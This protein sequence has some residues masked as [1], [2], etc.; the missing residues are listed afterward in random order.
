MRSYTFFLSP[1]EK[2]VQCQRLLLETYDDYIPTVQAVEYWYQ[3]F[4]IGDFDLEGKE[5]PG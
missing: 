2:A 4:K 5:R 1:E 3:Q